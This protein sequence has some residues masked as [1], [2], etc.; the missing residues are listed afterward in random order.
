M[1]GLKSGQDAAAKLKHLKKS[2]S[3]KL[4]LD[5]CVE[6]QE[7]ENG[8]SERMNLRNED[9]K[10]GEHGHAFSPV[11]M[12]KSL[13]G[14][15]AVLQTDIHFRR[16]T[17]LKSASA[18]SDAKRKKFDRPKQKSV[19]LDETHDVSREDLSRLHPSTQPSLAKAGNW[20]KRIPPNQIQS[21]HT[22]SAVNN[23]RT[24]LNDAASGSRRG[25]N[26]K[27]TGSKPEI[28]K[29]KKSKFQGANESDFIDLKLK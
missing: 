3:N 16:T 21:K 29:S 11:Q 2:S 8:S 7:E 19:L 10:D 27:P 5:Q 17:N 6:I 24:I 9:Y 20:Q 25:K 14:D 13:V 18:L 28:L 22:L 1:K 4:I 12:N 26:L 15:D 23:K